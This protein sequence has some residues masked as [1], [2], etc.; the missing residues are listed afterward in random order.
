MMLSLSCTIELSGAFSTND[1]MV[2]D[3][4]EY[5][6]ESDSDLEETE[7]I[8]EDIEVEETRKGVR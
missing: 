7:G 8:T 5:G 1:A 4:T 2:A 6:Y 3:T